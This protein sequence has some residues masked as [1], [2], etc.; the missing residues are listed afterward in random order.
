MSRLSLDKVL[1]V[2]SYGLSINNSALILG[3]LAGTLHAFIKKNKIH[4][5]GKKPNFKTGEK[6]HNSQLQKTT[7][8]GINNMT[9]FKRMDRG[10]SYEDAINTPVRKYNK[11]SDKKAGK[12]TK[13]QLLELSTL[14]ISRRGA[15]SILGVSSTLVNNKVIEFGIDWVGKP[16]HNAKWQ[17]DPCL[18]HAVKKLL[19][20]GQRGAKGQKQDVQEAIASLMRYLEMQTEDD[21]AKQ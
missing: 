3:V 13:E 18:Q 8:L 17:R 21:E 19:C 2:E 7:Y 9:V 5:R 14:G 4:W 6:D 15:A 20:A 10:M 16:V 11:K 12:I 1:E